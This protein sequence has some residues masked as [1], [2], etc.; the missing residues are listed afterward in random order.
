MK[1]DSF[2]DTP[3]SSKLKPEKRFLYRGCGSRVATLLY[4][5]DV[6]ICRRNPVRIMS[7][8]RYLRPVGH[9]QRRHLCDQV[10]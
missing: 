7:L 8:N 2:T 4:V 5:S 6:N 3:S 1:Y 10:H 9:L